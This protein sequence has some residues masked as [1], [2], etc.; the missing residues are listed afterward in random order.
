MVIFRNLIDSYKSTS[1]FTKLH[2]F[3]RFKTCPFLSIE[4]LIPKKGLI[5]DYGCGHGVFSHI[6]SIISQERKIYAIDI[7]KEKIKEAKKT[8]VEAARIKFLDDSDM[9]GL[10]KE[11][12]CIVVLDV[13]CYFSN[14][15]REEMLKRFYKALKPGATVVIKDMDKSLLIKYAWLY[16]QEF[17]TVKLLGITKASLLNFFDVEYLS[18]LLVGIGFNV[19]VINM[20]K[21]YLYPH[22]TFVCRK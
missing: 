21:H 17:L 8:I 1:F 6:L 16:L 9:N 12:D 14:Q 5:V 13:L 20:D 11:A 2:V 10:I 22:V 4:Q 18:K 19:Q 7:S 3:I 15:E